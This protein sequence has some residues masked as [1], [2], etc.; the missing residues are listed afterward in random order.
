MKK[1]IFLL[2][3]FMVLN[4]AA[5]SSD[6]PPVE[7]AFKE[8]P[9]RTMATMQVQLDTNKDVLLIRANLPIVEIAVKDLFDKTLIRKKNAN[10]LKLATLS[11]GVYTLEVRLEGTTFRKRIILQ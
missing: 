11:R 6:S 8:R 2:V 4:V 10:T 5:Q 7:L 1:S 3:A 9:T